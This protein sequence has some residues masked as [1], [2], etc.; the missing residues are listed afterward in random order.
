MLYAERIKQDLQRIADLSRELERRASYGTPG[1]RLLINEEV[2]ESG[3][4]WKYAHNVIPDLIAVLGEILDD[5][6]SNS[7]KFRW[8]KPLSGL[9]DGVNCVFCT[10]EKFR[11]GGEAKLLLYRNGVRQ[12]EGSE[13]DYT[14]SES[15]GP[16]TGWD[17]V[18]ILG[19]APVPGERLTADYLIP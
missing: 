7:D 8:D 15:G 16:G 10:P 13:S 14:V 11:H 6:A 9:V 1:Y 2:I 12:A 4:V 17:T 19:G 3:G 5:I 18:T